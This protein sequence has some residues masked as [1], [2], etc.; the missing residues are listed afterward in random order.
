MRI[1]PT[2]MKC[3]H[4]ISVKFR[5]FGDKAEIAEIIALGKREDNEERL[6]A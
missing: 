2:Q 5:Q 1:V 4:T 6:K 3:G